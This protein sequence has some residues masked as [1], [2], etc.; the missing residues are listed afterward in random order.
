M[1]KSEPQC[2]YGM[3]APAKITATY[4]NKYDAALHNDGRN[5]GKPLMR[6]HIPH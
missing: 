2:R 6:R 5:S 1:R 4:E 3:P